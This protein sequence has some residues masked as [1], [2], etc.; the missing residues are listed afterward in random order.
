MARA[1]P[2]PRVIRFIRNVF[3]ALGILVTAVTVTPLVSWWSHSLSGPLA[4]QHGE[5]LII[6]SSAS[7]PEGI[8]DA[9]SYWRAVYGVREWRCCGFRKIVISG[10]PPAAAIR[11]FLLAQGVP[12]ADIT[13]EPNATTTRE[14]AL[15]SKPLLAGLPGRKVLLTSDYHMLR[16]R[17]VFRKAGIA[18]IPRPIPDAYKRAVHPSNRWNVFLDLCVES[19][20]LLGYFT[21]G[22]I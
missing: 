17:M 13:V 20:K 16:A 19:A 15:F 22:W 3:L 11:D 5:V 18:V 12:A 2:L 8:P 1:G 9:S 4:D 14:N 21:R 6:L 7:L 10:G